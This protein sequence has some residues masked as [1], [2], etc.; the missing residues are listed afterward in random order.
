VARS[1]WLDDQKTVR[2]YAFTD[3]SRWT[4]QN[5]YRPVVCSNCSDLNYLR[6]THIWHFTPDGKCSP[7]YHINLDKDLEALKALLV[8]YVDGIGVVEVEQN[9]KWV[10][11]KGDG[12]FAEEVM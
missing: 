7:E 10:L 11:M 5:E 8:T 9:S 12:L 3:G 4:I 6:L 2:T 1:S